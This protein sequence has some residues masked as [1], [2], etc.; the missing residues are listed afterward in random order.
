MPYFWRDWIAYLLAFKCVIPNILNINKQ[1]WKDNQD[2]WVLIRQQ[3]EG[4]A[5]IDGTPA[6][7]H[8]TPDQILDDIRVFTESLHDGSVRHNIK[9]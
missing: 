4:G 2:K 7:V 1:E 5:N 6:T 8:D 3:V 9:K